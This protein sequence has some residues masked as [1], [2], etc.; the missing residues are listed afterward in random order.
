MN[1]RTLDALEVQTYAGFDKTNM[2]AR[3]L[4]SGLQ[5][6]TRKRPRNSRRHVGRNLAQ[7]RR[8]PGHDF[9]ALDLQSGC[10]KILA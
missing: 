6:S 1:I 4:Q 2:K 8:Q 10:G 7:G 3:I 5:K 9:L